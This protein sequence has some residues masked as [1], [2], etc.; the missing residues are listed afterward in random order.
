MKINQ[1]RTRKGCRAEQTKRVSYCHLH[2]VET[3][4]RVKG[5][6]TF[7]GE[8]R[9][10]SVCPTWRLLAVGTLATRGLSRSWTPMGLSRVTYL[11][12]SDPPSV[13]SGNKI[14][15]TV[16]YHSSPGHGGLVIIMITIWLL[17]G[18]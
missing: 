10:G 5:R 7:T 11:A 4:R 18:N 6:E 2:L 16:S 13:G 14:R 1:L 12:P 3:Q 17:V 15:K 9:E 8:K